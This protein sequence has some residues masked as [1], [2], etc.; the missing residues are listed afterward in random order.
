[1]ELTDTEILYI[2]TDDDCLHKDTNLRRIIKSKSSF[3]D[4]MSYTFKVKN[5]YKRYIPWLGEDVEKYVETDTITK[6]RDGNGFF[7]G[8]MCSEG[9]F[10]FTYGSY[11]TQHSEAL[12]K[13]FGTYLEVRW[14][15]ENILKVKIRDSS[16][17]LIEFNFFPHNIGPYIKIITRI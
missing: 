10:I 11:R 9:T 4:C 5:G 12:E 14:E 3:F 7:P 6:Y 2:G 8:Y 16:K 13:E 15:T 17:Y 1:M